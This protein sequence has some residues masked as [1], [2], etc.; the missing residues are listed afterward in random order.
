MPLFYHAIAIIAFT[1]VGT[2]L[3]HQYSSQTD[4]SVK[5]LTMAKS[6]HQKK[7]RSH[8][9][10][11]PKSN[12]TYSEQKRLLAYSEKHRVFA[13][14]SLKRY[15]VVNVVNGHE[16]PSMFGITGDTLR[17]TASDQQFEEHQGF[18]VF[19]HV[20]SELGKNETRYILMERIAEAEMAGVNE[21]FAYLSVKSVTAEIRNT[22]VAI[23]KTS[24]EVV[25]FNTSFI[26]QGRVIADSTPGGLLMPGK[27]V[28]LRLASG[29]TTKPVGALVDLHGHPMDFSH[30]PSGDRN[31][32]GQL[33]IVSAPSESGLAVGIVTQLSQFAS[34]TTFT[35][36]G[37]QQ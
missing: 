11:K 26:G 4:P 29:D 28:W 30:P 35:S 25:K 34:A 16:A 17:I 14:D 7:P 21:Q 2:S 20:S 1:T 6:W 36:Q 32:I 15:P 24:S 33:I 37:G 18:D 31:S 5:P 23:P 3:P 19:R 22:D 10:I 9:T 27:V 8:I 13:E 12:F